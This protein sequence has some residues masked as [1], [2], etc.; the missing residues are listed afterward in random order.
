MVIEVG[1]RG[2]LAEHISVAKGFFG[3]SRQRGLLGELS[4]PPS[5]QKDASQSSLYFC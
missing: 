1:S 5:Q 3:L 4:T 2:L